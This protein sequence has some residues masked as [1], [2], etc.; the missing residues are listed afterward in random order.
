MQL[1]VSSFAFGWAVGTPAPDG[2]PAFAADSLLD[3]AVAHAAPVIQ[4]GD[5]RPLH[6]LSDETPARLA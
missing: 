4:F 3:F 2:A 1:G 5:N 6:A